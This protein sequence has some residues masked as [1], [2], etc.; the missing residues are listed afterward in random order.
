MSRLFK[1]VGSSFL[2]YD[3]ETIGL[4]HVFDQVVRAA[5][6]RTTPDFKELERHEIS[7]KLNPDVIPSPGALVVNRLSM[8]E[9]QRGENEYD[10]MKKIHGLVNKPGTISV[11]YNSLGFDD[12]FLR[13]GF[14]RNL[15]QPY[16]HQSK[17]GCGRMDIYP[18]TVAYSLL[19]NNHLKW[20]MKNDVP[21]FKLE[22]MNQANQLFAGRAHDAMSDV[23][24]TLALAKRLREDQSTWDLCTQF[25]DKSN[26]K[27]RINEC[28]STLAV[29]GIEYK[30]GLMINHRSKGRTITPVLLLGESHAS[31]NQTIFL[32]MDQVLKDDIET[33][34]TMRKKMGESPFFM[35]IDFKNFDLLPSDMKNEFFEAG[36]WLQKNPTALTKMQAHFLNH[37]YPKQDCDVSAQ[38]YQLS[39]PTPAEEMLFSRFHAA[40]LEDKPAIAAQF[41]RVE[42]RHLTIRLFGRHHPNWLSSKND[43]KIFDRHMRSVFSEEGMKSPVDYKGEGQFSVSDAD[44]EL[45]KLT[46]KTLD[47]EQQK[48][49]ESYTSWLDVSKKQ[50][51]EVTSFIAP[52]LFKAPEKVRQD[53]VIVADEFTVIPAL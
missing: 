10:A 26:D 29:G 25:F 2:F 37:Q 7:V 51:K 4:S 27:K 1:S 32:R 11:G 41:P 3:F 6:I 28:P 48:I 24:T 31:S 30:I 53:K 19:R 15:L 9:L 42:H 33:T 36:E 17:N 18:M 12:L 38:L 45:Q 40:K 34:K 21:S 22:S 35:P 50:A 13:F 44:I 23:E 20:M 49:I 5:F 43:I 14:Y 47:P 16:S 39:F 46:R 52:E 8:D